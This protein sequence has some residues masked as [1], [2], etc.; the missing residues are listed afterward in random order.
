MV[1]SIKIEN[2]RDFQ[3]LQPFLEALKLHTNAKV[4]VSTAETA[5]EKTWEDKLN[6]FF[7]FLETHAVRVQKIEHLTRD[8]LN[9]R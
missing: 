5:F 1:I 7:G 3:W 8:E 6:S 4:E 9:E 2:Q